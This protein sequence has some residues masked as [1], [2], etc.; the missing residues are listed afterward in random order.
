MKFLTKI[1]PPLQGSQ[2]PRGSENQ[3]TFLD[4]FQSNCFMITIELEETWP[5]GKSLSIMIEIICVL[6][7]KQN[8]NKNH[9]RTSDFRCS[10]RESPPAYARSRSQLTQLYGTRRSHGHLLLFHPIFFLLEPMGCLVHLGTQ[11]VENSIKTETGLQQVQSSLCCFLGASPPRHRQVLI[12]T[13]HGLTSQT[14]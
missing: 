4:H 7:K 14:L 5:L 11:A 6:F 13:R 10:S 3:I 2:K 8:K 12:R 1:L 9:C